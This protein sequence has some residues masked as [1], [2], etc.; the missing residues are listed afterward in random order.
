MMLDEPSI[1]DNVALAVGVLAT[2]DLDDEPLFS[3]DEVYDI[4]PDGL[5]AYEF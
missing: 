4:R 1:A 5:L 3:T 2:I